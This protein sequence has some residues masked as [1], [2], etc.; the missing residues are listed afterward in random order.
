MSNY[1]DNE[2]LAYQLG[3]IDAGTSDYV[4]DVA[5]LE[6]LVAARRG[7]R[8]LT[9]YDPLA[10]M[11]A[12]KDGYAAAFRGRAVAKGMHPF[13]R[14]LLAHADFVSSAMSARSPRT[15]ADIAARLG[16]AAPVNT[17]QLL[18]IL[19]A[20]TRHGLATHSE[21]GWTLTRKDA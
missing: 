20:M 11:N 21:R 4:D 13:D 5:L 3:V 12:Y 9:D 16:G 19:A 1:T 18:Q 15:P 2:Q 7:G 17:T 10:L 6:Q 8:H 14:A